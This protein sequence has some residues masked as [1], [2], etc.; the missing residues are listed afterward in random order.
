MP[1]TNTRVK[2]YTQ[3]R[4]GKRVRVNTYQQRREIGVAGAAVMISGL[5]A[6]AGALRL[7][8]AVFELVTALLIVAIALCGI[9]TGVQVLGKRRGGRHAGRRTTRRPGRKPN[10]V[11][12]PVKAAKRKVKSGARRVGRRMWRATMRGAFPFST[13]WRKP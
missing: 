9:L 3:T 6:V 7:L 10:P 13:R 8:S 12:H 5:T 4:N 11:L 2:G 1:R